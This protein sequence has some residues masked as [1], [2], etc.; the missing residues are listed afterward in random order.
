MDHSK[1]AT[2]LYS[3]DALRVIAIIAVIVIHETTKTLSALNLLI[4]MAPFSLFLNQVARFAVPLFFLIS[5]FVLELN[6]KSDMSYGAYF[7]K[8]ASR[9]IVPFV[10]WS[11]FYYLLGN[12][13]NISSLLNG[14][15]VKALYEGT[16]SYHLYFIPTLIIFYLAFPIL[17]KAL[18]ILKKPITLLL[19]LAVQF[20]LLYNDYY[21][22]AIQMHTVFRVVILSF[23]MFVFGMAASHH[24]EEIFAFAKKRIKTLIIL[25][26]ALFLLIYPYVR[27]ITLRDDTSSYIYNQFSPL[28]YVYTLLLTLVVFY[29]F[30]K[31]QFGRKTFIALSKLSFFVFF[32]HVF[33]QYVVWDFMILKYVDQEIWKAFWFDPV[34]IV[35]I[36]TISFGI[37]YVVHKIPFASKITS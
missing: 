19:L 33:I 25:L 27:M 3:I 34:I 7:K 5:G 29:L 10:A 36:T 35:I 31:T 23:A 13:F 15:Y 20:L 2:Y 12:N 24:K 28:N 11:T 8:R 37:A 6:N 14:H 22:G 9:V 26:A 21:N 4:D 30:E 1:K 16:A 18:P 32:I 17:H